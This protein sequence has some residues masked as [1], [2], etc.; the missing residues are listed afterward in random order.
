MLQRYQDR[1]TALRKEQEQFIADMN[2]QRG[3]YAGRIAELEMT[4]KDL[5]PE[6]PK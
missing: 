6:P 4:I 3:I 2:V 5:T 1:L